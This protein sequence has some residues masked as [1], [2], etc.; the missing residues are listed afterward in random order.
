MQGTLLTQ[1]FFRAGI[2]ETDAWQRLDADELTRFRARIEAIFGVFPADSQANE[3]V[4]ETEIVFPVL[5]ALGWAYLPQQTASGKGRQDVP[6][7]LLFVDTATK[8][9]A[10]AERR[11]EQRYRRG[12]AIVECKRW[13]RPLDRGDRTDPLDANAPS[14][15]M[16]RYLSRVEVASER[17]IRWGLLTNGRYWRLYFQG[18]RSRSEEFLELDL[19]RLAGMKGLP[20]DLFDST[21]QDA[22]HFLAV[23]YLLFGPTGFVPQ[24]N[25]P[26]NRAFLAIALAEARRWEA[27]VSQDLGEMVF[28][29]LF[30]RLVAAMVEH[31]PAASKPPTAEDLDAVRREALILLYRLLFVLYAEDRNLLPIRDP[32]YGHYSLRVIR[33]K[34]A[35]HLDANAVFSASA[36]RY[37]HILKDLFHIIGQ[38]DASLGV[39]P[40][41]GG[42]FDDRAHAL[43]ERLTLPDAVVAELIDG[44]SRRAVGSERRW[45][46][47]RD[48]SVQ[49]LGSIYER[50]LE[51][52][53]VGDGAGQIQVSP[54]IFARKG[55]GSYYTHDDLVQLLI[56][57]T[58]G[59]LL[60]ERAEA[61]QRQVEA[62]G[63]LRSPTPQRVRD[64]QDHDPAAA[65]LELKICDPAMGS[66]HFLV[67]LVDYLADQILER[68][69]DSTARVHWADA[70]EPYVSPLA[71]RIADIRERI[72]ASSRAHGWAVDPAQL[73]DRHIVRRMI[74][75]RVIFGVDKNP[76]AVELAKV[77]LWLHTFT[78]GAPLSFLDHHLR[79]GDAL[80]GERLDKVLD[81][82]RAFGALFQTNEL[83]RIAVA[84][85]SMNRIADLTDVDIAEVHQSR[86]LFEQIDAE[87][88]PLRKLLDFWQALRWLPA[89]DPVRQRGWA[90]LASGR[91]GD[92]IEVIDAGSVMAG[93]PASDEART[94]QALLRQTR[95]LAGQEGFLSW[96]IAF[97]TVWRHLDSGQP[98]G[99]FDAL[100]GNPPWDRMKLQEVEWFAARQPEIAHAVRAADRKRLIDQLE[101]A[102]DGLWLEYRQARNRA[103]TAARIAR[104]SGEYPL[105]S[106]GDVNLYALFVERAQSLVNDQGI[107]GLLT[108]SGIASDKGSSAFFQ[109]IATAGRLAA[110]LDFEN[111]KVFFPDVHSR[112]KFC[113]LVFGGAKRTFP[114]TR[115]AFFLHAV[116]ELDDPQR[117]FDLSAEDF[118]AVNPNTGT[119]PIFRQRRDAEITRTIYSRCPVLVDRH[120]D[121]PQPVWPV[122][123]LRMFDMTNDSHWFKRR[124]ELEAAGFY[125]VGGQR[126][127]KG[128]EE[129]V[130]L[131]EGKM[132]QAY[133]H[134]A[135]SIVVN[136][137]NLHRPAQPEP[138]SLKQHQDVNW[139]PEPQFWIDRQQVETPSS[140]QWTLAFKDVTA[141]TNMRTMIAM[142]VGTGGFGNTLPV[143]LPDGANGEPA[144][145]RFA[146][147]LLANFNSFV[148]DFIA[149][150]KV[151]GQHLN[152]YIV[153]QIPVIAPHRFETT[154]GNQ[155]IADF[156]REQVLRL[157]YTAVDLRPFAAD[158]G[159]EGE[160]FVWDEEDRRHRLARL[161]A[162]FFH[163]YGLDRND[164]DYILAQFPIVREQ[165]EK[166]FG[167]YLTRDLILAY[168]N[169][170]AAGD[171]ET[172]VEVR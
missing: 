125:P 24:P 169:A 135:A 110:L 48:L 160:P 22:A 19:A 106:G 88:A 23:F 6:D 123:Y 121:P 34:I 31:D 94:I 115:C 64:L 122:R 4:T 52:R 137:A 46:N 83:A 103:E 10:L 25:D 166:Q 97:P 13:Q 38:G 2:K 109:N 60:D 92:V 9:A 37:Y 7:V 141:P 74:L 170:V 73:D 130:P 144:Y 152:L 157:S 91:F 72:L 26:E 78:V 1:D 8:R 77:A 29:R 20:A 79:A 43:L 120:T 56:R 21:S 30:P 98:R 18:A 45:I 47:Y 57:Q 161:D 36:G 133:D 119:A 3:A 156:I 5:E 100:I 126:W 99:G 128:K 149:R 75:K 82:L 131:Y 62:L 167:R 40:Y 68:M 155:T 86:H 11:D 162:L 140:I 39:P 28:E 65:L 58:V 111:R 42:L 51:Y 132:V 59:P 49:Q 15:Q 80:Y 114:E 105:L 146:P 158:M 17:A 112:F 93:D 139:L 150:Q 129:Y 84:T 171:L 41:N 134:R 70:A 44:L 96:A 151:Q 66:G 142:I 14:N 27:R 147:L 138:A 71:R 85:A 113:A 90:D 61:F 67:S 55:S 76:M 117:S 101:K 53:V 124:D 153:E 81:E 136:P 89:N 159:Y 63:R 164:A 127:R 33:Q 165:D 108:P 154:I 95:E 54:N 69:A 163:L 32:R 35:R 104:D 102:G 87:L 50:L 116:A 172:V 148:F 143:W 168:L 145:R 107:V 118:A 12:V 16:L